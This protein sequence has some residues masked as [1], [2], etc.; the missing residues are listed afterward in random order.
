MA[1]HAAR[2]ATKA[3]IEHAVAAA[4]ACGLDPAGI[5]ITPDGAIRV[6]EARASPQPARSDFD[7]FEAEL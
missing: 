1:A 6:V 4:R 7:R 5:E 3:K 2:Y